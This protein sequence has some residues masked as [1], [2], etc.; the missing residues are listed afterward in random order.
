MD[1]NILKTHIID[2][3]RDKLNINANIMN[4]HIFYSMKDDVKGHWR[5]LE[6]TFMFI[7]SLFLR[8]FFCLKHYENANFPWNKVWHQKS[9]LCYWEVECVC[10][11][12]HFNL[13]LT[14]TYVHIDKF[15]PCVLI[16]LIFEQLAWIHYVKVKWRNWN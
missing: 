9:L 12:N 16:R 1:V 7:R 5:S 13:A 14:L 2:N 6:A 3:L 8:Y 10:F 15:C 4:T 11:S